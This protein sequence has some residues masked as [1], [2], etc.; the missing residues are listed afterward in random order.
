MSEK[1]WGGRFT[2]ET[3]PLM[4]TFQESIGF[5]QCMWRVDLDGSQAYARALGKAGMLTS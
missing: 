2:G 4:D 5:D 1:L 3:D